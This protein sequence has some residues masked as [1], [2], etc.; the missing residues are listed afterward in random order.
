MEKGF[1]IE[2]TMQVE[3]K[4]EKL[5]L[6]TTVINPIK[7]SIVSEECMPDIL[8]HRRYCA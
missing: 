8:R 2:K 1:E 3:M 5:K 7:K 6:P 4:L